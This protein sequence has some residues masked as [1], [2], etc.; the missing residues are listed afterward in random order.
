MASTSS[1]V[2]DGAVLGFVRGDA[3]LGVLHVFA[4]QAEDQVRDGLA[5]Q[6]VLAGVAGP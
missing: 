4:A 1:R 2:G 5:E 6:R 3:G